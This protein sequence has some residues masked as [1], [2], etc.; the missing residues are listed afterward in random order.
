MVFIQYFHS[1]EYCFRLVDFQIGS[2]HETNMLIY[3]SS[4]Q[5]VGTYDAPVISNRSRLILQIAILIGHYSIGRIKTFVHLIAIKYDSR[6]KLV[7]VFHLNPLR[8][9][10]RT[11]IVKSHYKRKLLYGLQF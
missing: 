7:Y 8:T 11:T 10:S 2:C 4:S 3:S 6:T 5:P 9:C 1:I